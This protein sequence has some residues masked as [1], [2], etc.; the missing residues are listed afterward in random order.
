MKGDYTHNQEILVTMRERPEWEDLMKTPSGY[1]LTCTPLLPAFAADGER[2]DGER[3]EDRVKESGMVL[4]IDSQHPLTTVPRIHSTR[5]N[6]CAMVL[7]H[8]SV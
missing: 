8:S 4:K 2:E 1:F 3:E 7:T 6:V 5:R